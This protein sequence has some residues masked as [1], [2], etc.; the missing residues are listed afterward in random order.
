[1][2]KEKTFKFDFYELDNCQQHVYC[3]S[4]ASDKI[5]RKID[6]LMNNKEYFEAYKKVKGDFIYPDSVYAKY[7]KDRNNE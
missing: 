6:D 2:L 4:S 3:F 5:V 1:M 7:M